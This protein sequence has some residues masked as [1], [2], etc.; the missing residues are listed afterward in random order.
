MFRKQQFLPA[1][2]DASSVHNSSTREC[3]D[4]SSGHSVCALLVLLKYHFQLR[5]KQG[6]A[7]L[8]LVD[9]KRDFCYKV[10]EEEDESKC[11]NTF[12]E[13]PIFYHSLFTKWMMVNYRDCL[14]YVLSIQTSP[15]EKPHF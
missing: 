7:Q 3:K 6:D 9:Y 2:K 4:G 10:V 5:K 11:L 12:S 13:L 15:S 8:R 1:L 14:K